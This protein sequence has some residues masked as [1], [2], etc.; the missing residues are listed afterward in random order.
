[1][2]QHDYEIITSERA[3]K[4][5]C[6]IENPEH[7]RDSWRVNVR[8]FNLLAKQPT[9]ISWY[10][11]EVM[12]AIEVFVN[13]RINAHPRPDPRNPFRE[14][15]GMLDADIARND[16]KLRLTALMAAVARSADET[17]PREAQSTNKN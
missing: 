4:N 8:S 9:D 7:F 6:E 2:S 5:E 3:V 16:L 10:V 12:S 13:A 1:M 11:D 15:A 17:R 14:C